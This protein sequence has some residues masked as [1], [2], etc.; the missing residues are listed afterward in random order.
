MTVTSTAYSTYEN[1]DMLSGRKWD[2]LTKSGTVPKLGTIAVDE[3]IIPLGKKV[4]IPKLNMVFVAEDTG[5]AIKGNRIDIF[6]ESIEECMKWGVQKI[7]I[8]VQP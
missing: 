2:G 4:Y 3:K 7:D 1:G 5:S 8:Y 6:F